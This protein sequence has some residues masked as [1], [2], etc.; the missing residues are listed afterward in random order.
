VADTVVVETGTFA[1]SGTE[2]NGQPFRERLRFIATW[3]K[4]GATWVLVA[5]QTTPIVEKKK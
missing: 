4:Q 3:V 1:S 2:E 5:E